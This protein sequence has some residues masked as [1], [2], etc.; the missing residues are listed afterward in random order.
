M[1]LAAPP[2][3]LAPLRPEA[4]AVAGP[5]APPVTPPSEEAW[6]LR[7]SQG[8]RQEVW[9]LGGSVAGAE[10]GGVGFWGVSGRGRGRRCGVWGAQWQGQR[11]EVWGLGGSVAGAE[12]GCVR[13]LGGSVA[14]A[15]AGGVGFRVQWQMPGLW[16]G[17]AEAGVGFVARAGRG[18]RCGVWGSNGG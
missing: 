14:G 7:L 10:A 3:L 17:Q 4:P 16:L 12:A 9:G 13:G 8:Q 1:A 5:L 11:Q 2:T 15:E 6:R 18:R